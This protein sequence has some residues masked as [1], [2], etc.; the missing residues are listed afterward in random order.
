MRM[1]EGFSG[2]GRLAQ[3]FRNGGWEADTVD[4]KDGQDIMTW[5][6]TEHY[7]YVHFAPPCQEYSQLSHPRW[8][9]KYEAD[10]A[11]WL[12]SDE[13]IRKIRPRFHTKENVKGAQQVWGRAF[14]HYGPFFFWGYCPKIQVEIPWTTSLKGF[15]FDRVSMRARSDS[16]SA[17]SR[18]E[19]PQILCDAIFLAVESGFLLEP[20]L[21]HYWGSKKNQFVE[22]SAQ[23]SAP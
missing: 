21:S 16:R 4:I 15:K 12:R 3:T 1:L 13:L 17:E 6:P 18:A 9:Q 8:E 11:L 14:Y 19:Y 5:E 22:P 20:N 7:D 23:R 10:P 2:S